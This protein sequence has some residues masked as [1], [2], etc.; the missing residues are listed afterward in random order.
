MDVDVV[1][2]VNMYKIGKIYIIGK[3]VFPVDKFKF[4]ESL[5]IYS[6]SYSSL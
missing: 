6:W 4:S 5:K 1:D 3:S 2:I